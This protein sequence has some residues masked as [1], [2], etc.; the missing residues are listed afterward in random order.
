MRRARAAKLITGTFISHHPNPAGP[1]IAIT[2]GEPAGI[3]PDLCVLLAQQPQAEK[4]VGIASAGL[5]AQRAQ[6]LGLAWHG[7]PFG[8][9]RNA[10]FTPGTME[11]ID[12]PLAAPVTAGQLDRANSAYVLQTLETA[13]DGCTSGRFA[14]MVTAPVH[15]GVIN[16]AG[17]AF[18]GHTE[19]LEARTH[20]A[21]VV[22]MLVGGGLRVALATTHLAVKDIA[23]HITGE[24]LEQTLRVLQR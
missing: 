22:M 3:G 5:L 23:R 1:V 21:H 4:L 8:G 14:A 18:T 7:L 13:A 2:A 10:A 6:Q 20:A 15:K 17:I 16:D 24:S 11:I 12:V 19:F 9:S